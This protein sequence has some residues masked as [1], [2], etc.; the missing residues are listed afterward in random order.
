MVT[1]KFLLIATLLGMFAVVLGAFGAH[2]LKKLLS[3]HEIMIFETG[4][5]YQFYHTFALLMT[6]I[7]GRYL[8]ERWVSIAGWLFIMGTALFSGSLYLIALVPHVG[9]EA[10][11]GIL[12]PMTP[13]GG[14]LLMGGWL[15]LFRAAFDYKKN[16]GNR[17]S[18]TE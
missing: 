5:R 4:V 13:L 8:S 16:K 6:A 7:L 10:S 11:M 3:E 15:A 9:L 2:I 12:G 1:R 17:K 14:V 18:L